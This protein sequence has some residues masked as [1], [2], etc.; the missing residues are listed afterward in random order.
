MKNLLAA[1]AFLALLTACSRDEITTY[2]PP[3]LPVEQAEE[4]TYR[5]VAAILPQREKTWF[6]KVAG[7]VERVFEHREEFD[8]FVRSF[9]FTGQRGREIEWTVPGGWE[10]NK[11]DS[12]GLRLAS[13]RM[14]PKKQQLE[15]TVVGLSNQAKE[16]TSVLA[17]VN[18][19]RD[20]LG[21]EPIAEGDLKDNLNQVIRKIE[22]DNVS[23]TVVEIT[24]PGKAPEPTVPFMYK[25]PDGWK[26][27][28]RSVKF[29]DLTLQAVEGDNIA[30]LT[31]SRL[32]GGGLLHN[33]NRWRGQVDLD[34]IKQEQLKDVVKSIK[35]SGK[36]APYMH[37]EGKQQSILGAIVE[38]GDGTWY[39]K[40]MGPVELIKREEPKFKAFL[41]SIQFEA[42]EKK[43]G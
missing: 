18:R 24:G 5:L 28:R 34:D 12:G 3:R 31:V 6:V 41:G 33:V 39:F 37:L 25:I 29:S 13:F 20:Q 38:R 43:D 32:G 16:A 7:T 22:V 19:W 35:V 14:G 1:I 30:Q 11:K 26:R 21:L 10:E 36:D 2:Y 42:E 9:K 17:N 40:M 8:S 27:A 4:G 23:A 15:V